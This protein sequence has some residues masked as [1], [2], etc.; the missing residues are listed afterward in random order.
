MTRS[1]LTSVCALLLASASFADETHAIH[2]EGA[3]VSAAKA[4][5]AA[6]FDILAA[7]AHR[8]G[9]LVTFHMTTNGIAGAEQPDPAGALGGAPVLS[10]VWPTSLD[11][12]A[13]GF[14]GGTG[15][16]ALAATSHP[17]FD[18]T[19]LYDENNDGDPANDGLLW[20]SHWVV[21][22]LTEACGDGA[23][24]V[25]DIPEGTAPAMPATWPGLPVFIDSPGYTPL[26][27]GPEITVTVPFVSAETVAG[28][29]YDGV[30]SAL[31]VNKNIHAPLL[32]VTDVFDVASGDLSLPGAI[33]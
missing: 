26:F 28:A 16:L 25:R 21:L 30:T 13:V 20:H 8:D 33:N 1:L 27:E 15:I 24:G 18:D 23:L 4:S 32:C 22:T 10:Y 19:P 2:Q 7:H 5:K 17:D 12:A 11:P 31:R 14:E 29:A 6:A 3:I 9:R